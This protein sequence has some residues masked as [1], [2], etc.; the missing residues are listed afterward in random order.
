MSCD[1]CDGFYPMFSATAACRA[2]PFAGCPC[3]PTLATCGEPR[4]CHLNDCRGVYIPGTIDEAECSL[5]YPGCPCIPT[6]ATCGPPQSCDA[7]GCEGSYLPNSNEARCTRIRRG[8]LC[9]PTETVSPFLSFLLSSNKP[10]APE[11]PR[12]P[13]ATSQN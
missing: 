6:A 12:L 13:P 7:D 8:C 5:A 9:T 1:D 11:P 4:E 10:P 3:V 2:G